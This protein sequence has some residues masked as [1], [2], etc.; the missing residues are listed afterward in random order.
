ME[1]VRGCEGSGRFDVELHGRV[2]ETL[3]LGGGVAAD[4]LSFLI[5]EY[6]PHPD[7]RHA[8]APLSGS[9]CILYISNMFSS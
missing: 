8:V 4:A 6:L 7:V 3:L 1:G 2:V 9:R 5:T